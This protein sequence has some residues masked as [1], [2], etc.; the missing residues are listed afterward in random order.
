MESDLGRTRVAVSD[1]V[2]IGAD[3]GAFVS[4]LWESAVLIARNNEL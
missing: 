4:S 3:F 1:V 2:S